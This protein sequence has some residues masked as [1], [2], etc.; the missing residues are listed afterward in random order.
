MK[1]QHGYKANAK[2]KK[3]INRKKINSQRKIPFFWLLIILGPTITSFI[4]W[5]IF[6]SA[7]KIDVNKEVI[8]IDLDLEENNY[9]IIEEEIEEKIEEEEQVQDFEESFLRGRN[10]F[11]AG[12]IIRRSYD[13]RLYR[14]AI[15]A[16]LPP[17]QD[18][19]YFYEAWMVRP[20]LLEYFSI[21]QFFPREDGKYGLLYEENFP[22]LVDD[23]LDYSRIIITRESRGRDD[24]P[25]PTQIAEGEFLE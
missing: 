25:S 8:G 24:G 14:V 2:A 18:E 19:Y 7:E 22:N 6:F 20:G 9:G 10:G 11:I 15:V 5:S 1:Y 3:Q 13:G 12:G 16:D 21:G 23:I 17:Q 4:I